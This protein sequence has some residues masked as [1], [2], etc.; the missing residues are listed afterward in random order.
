MSEI[1]FV[2]GIKSVEVSTFLFKQR[3]FLKGLTSIT[4]N[5]LEIQLRSG[6]AV[7]QTVA[8]WI[9]WHGQETLI[10]LVLR[11]F[12]LEY[13]GRDIKQAIHHHLVPR[14]GMSGVITSLRLHSYGLQSFCFTF[15]CY[16]TL[17]RVI[18]HGWLSAMRNT[19]SENTQI[20]AG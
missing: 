5:V 9:L 14:L 1:Y 13:I 2:T 17:Y 7:D 10:P 8:V 12:L 6:Q 3:N 15:T 4:W 16:Y 20:N 18:L 19:F 11:L